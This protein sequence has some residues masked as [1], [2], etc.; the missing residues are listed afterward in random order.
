M[1]DGRQERPGSA[2]RF[3]NL[4]APDGSRDEAIA[5]QRFAEANDR[6]PTMAERRH[7]RQLAEFASP[8]VEPGAATAWH[9]V[10]SA[11][12]EAVAAGSSFV[13]PKRIREIL[14]RWSRDGVPAEYAGIV[15]ETPAGD[16][17]SRPGD[18][19]VTGIRSGGHRG[20]AGAGNA[21]ADPL[22]P[23]GR[24]A[25]AIWENVGR[26]VSASLGEAGAKDVLAGTA[27]V[28][29]DAG[30][31]TIRVR[32]GAQAETLTG[33][34]A[35]LLGRALR[36]QLRRPVR[37]ATVLA[38]PTTATADAVDAGAAAVRGG[39]ASSASRR[40]MRDRPTRPEPVTLGAI[41][42]FMVEQCGLT[43]RQ[44]WSMALNDLR[45]GG[46]IPAADIDAWLRDAALLAMEDGGDGA[47]TFLLGVPHVLAQRRVEARFRTAIAAT[48]A[49]LLGDGAAE[50]SLE[51]TIIREWHS[52]HRSA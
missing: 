35:A 43:N 23:N 38:E 8:I 42:V 19:A 27:I 37:L 45:E 36:A 21:D 17:V 22:L 13:A 32:D 10:S 31:V 47:V 48:L 49:M 52:L 5:L 2:D 14:A 51:V 9:L 30:E 15:P 29:Y 4:Q 28:A 11:I 26:E 41:P 40:V 20:D 12:E 44:L 39:D 34:H 50:I 46:V 6:Q 16:A 24:S 1:A 18:P 7:L 25:R 3:G 33:E